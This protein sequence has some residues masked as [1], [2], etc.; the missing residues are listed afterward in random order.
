MASTLL[1]GITINEI[2][3]DP[4]GANNFDTDGNG[5]AR[6]ADEFIELVNTSNSAIDISGLELWDRGRDNW[7]T[8]PP[9][10]VLEPGAV[11]V[12]VRN[13]QNGGSL[14]SVTG[15]NLAFDANYG[16]GVFNNNGDNIVVYDPT[17]DEFIQAIYN[18]DT[19]DDP[20]A[21]PGYS[22]F[23]ST[24]TQSGTTEDFGNDQ[25]GFSIQRTSAGFNNSLTPTPGA[26]IVCFASGTLL[27]TPK[28]F[29]PI[30]TLRTGD[31]VNTMD[32]GWQPIRWIFARRVTLADLLADPHLLP[33]EV[34]AKIMGD[35]QPSKPL[36]ISRQHRILIEGK[37]AQRMFG[38]EQILAAAKDLTGCEGIRVHRPNTS[39]FY[40]HVLLEK[41]QILNANGIAAES[42]FLGSEAMAI[43]SKDAQEELRLLFPYDGLEAPALSQTPSRPLTSGARVRTL[44]KRHVKNERQM[45]A[46]FQQPLKQERHLEG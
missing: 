17:N 41:H 18:V 8:F 22:G 23:S 14:P 20:V 21:G 38:S 33:I 1:G 3:V 24:A 30:A 19:V 45:L 34:S 31:L 26:D 42:L 43:L 44:V 10:T 46:A 15:D 32:D 28:G 25:D 35:D 37:I 2:L 11:A 6:S 7:F 5:V 4:N 40:Y 27:E 9:G 13:V 16:S 36:L 39:F 12:V 29:T